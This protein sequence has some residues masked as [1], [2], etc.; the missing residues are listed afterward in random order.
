MGSME[1]VASRGGERLT[2]RERILE[3][4]HAIFQAYLRKDRAAIRRG[5]TE[6]W[7]G[8]VARSRSLIRG[9]EAY[10][11]GAEESLAAFE[12]V[13]YEILDSEIHVHGDHATVFYLARYWIRTDSG[14]RPI[15]LRA[16][17]LYRRDPEGWNQWGSNICL[18]PEGA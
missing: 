3:H 14:E 5:H 2:D 18:V 7:R 9:I 10:M 8:F 13:R 1:H 16:V 4:I 17:D 11:E 15:G 6:D 12:G